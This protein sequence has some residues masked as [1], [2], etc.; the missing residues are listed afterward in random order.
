MVMEIAVIGY[1]RP[2]GAKMTE[3]DY[4]TVRNV[5]ARHH[6]K[7]VLISPAGPTFGYSEP[8]SHLSFHLTRLRSVVLKLMYSLTWKQSFVFYISDWYQHMSSLTLPKVTYVKS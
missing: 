5:E 6:V 3:P 1:S 2:L 7:C 8:P 4:C